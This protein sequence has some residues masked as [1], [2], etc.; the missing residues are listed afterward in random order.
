MKKIGLTITMKD[1]YTVAELANIWHEITTNY[2]ITKEA[3]EK[4][5]DSNTES[6]YNIE[7]SNMLVL[8]HITTKITNDDMIKVFDYI[9]GIDKTIGNDIIKIDKG[10]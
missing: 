9:A 4:Y 2:K 8:Q 5:R 7:K 6:L 10:E 3:Y 1:S